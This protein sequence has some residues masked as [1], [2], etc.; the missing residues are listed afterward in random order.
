MGG[1]I[2]TPVKVMEVAVPISALRRTPGGQ[3]GSWGNLGRWIRDHHYS[4]RT[5]IQVVGVER[6]GAQL[7]PERPRVSLPG[8]RPSEVL[9][10]GP[11]ATERAVRRVA[12]QRARRWYGMVT[13][14]LDGLTPRQAVARVRERGYL[15]A[16]EVRRSASGRGSHVRFEGSHHGWWPEQVLELRRQLGDDPARV[17]LDARRLARRPGD[18][19]SVRGILFDRKGD[20]RAGR[21]REVEAVR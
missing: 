5:V 17:V 6:I 14:D 20:R 12:G 16:L 13:L 4:K 8:V 19:S 11:A 18:R 9:E 21:W 2:P 1:R 3:Y 7:A 15:G 10:V